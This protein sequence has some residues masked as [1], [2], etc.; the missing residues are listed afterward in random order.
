MIKLHAQTA[1]TILPEHIISFFLVMSAMV[2]M[3]VYVQRGLQARVHDVR[4][5]AMNQAARA[6]TSV[7]SGCLEAAGN[8]V[9]NNTFVKEYEPYYGLSDAEVTRSHDEQKGMLGG[10]FTR[11][12]SDSTHVVSDS[13]QLP[14]EMAK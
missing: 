11:T 3:T 1:Q 4:D 12:S 10:V 14:P 6:C 8:V 13:R 2:A 5:Y 7:G 9:V